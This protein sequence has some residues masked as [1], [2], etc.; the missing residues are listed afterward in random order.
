MVQQT[1]VEIVQ[2]VYYSGMEEYKNEGTEVIGSALKVI[3][4]ALGQMICRGL[5][6]SGEI[7]DVL[8]DVRT[9]L[10]PSETVSV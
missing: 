1:I 8:L 9:L 7:T 6:S 4:K 5:V 3:D 10:S 2:Q